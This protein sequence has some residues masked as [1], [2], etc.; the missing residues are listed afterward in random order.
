M[1]QGLGILVH[2]GNHWI[3]RG[4]LPNRESTPSWL[5]RNKG[6]PTFRTWRAD[7]TERVSFLGLVGSHGMRHVND[8]GACWLALGPWAPPRDIMRERMAPGVRR[9][10][11]PWRGLFAVAAE[12]RVFPVRL[13]NSIGAYV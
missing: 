12:L 9:P 11:R 5:G 10:H 1:K 3:V 8:P 4:P 6:M 2:E 13:R 7:P